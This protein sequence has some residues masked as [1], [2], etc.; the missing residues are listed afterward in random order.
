MQLTRLQ[1]LFLA[2]LFTQ[3]SF[4]TRASASSQRPIPQVVRVESGGV[5]V[6]FYDGRTNRIAQ[7]QRL[8][9]WTLMAVLR[10]GSKHPLAVFEDFSQLM[11]SLLFASPA[12]EQLT[13]L[14]SLEPT[15]AEPAS[16]Y[17]GHTLQEV[18]NSDSDLLGQELLAKAGDPV[19]E[20]VAACLPPISRMHV[21][22]FVGTHNCL[23]KV[24]IFYGGSTPNFD[25]AAYMPAIEK[26][27][28]FVR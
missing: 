9:D 8:G 25:P 6:G 10:A 23:E 18:R 19:F 27:R 2:L 14:K 5:V 13:L 24:G 7:G 4:F 26:I 28:L 11:G 21:Y 15:W 12:G 22:T 20:A 16:L 17:G 1:A 3:P